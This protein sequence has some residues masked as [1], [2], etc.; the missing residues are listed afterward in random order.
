MNKKEL[1]KYIKERR[2]QLSITQNDIATSLN[3]TTQAVSRWENGLSCPDFILLGDLSDLLKVTIDDLLTLNIPSELY[4]N[5]L[6]FNYLTFGQTINKYLEYNNLT[7][8][9]FSNKSK[10]NQT[11]ISNIINGKAFPSINQFITIANI[12][13]IK[14]S[15][16]YF[17][18]FIIYTKYV[19]SNIKNNINHNKLIISISVLLIFILGIIRIN[20]SEK[21]E[22]NSEIKKDDNYAYIEFWDQNANLLDCQKKEYG[23]DVYNYIEYHPFL[24]WNREISPAKTSTI[25]KMMKNPAELALYIHYDNYASYYFLDSI[26]DF[27]IYSLYKG[28]YY[29]TSLKDYF[30]NPFDINNITPGEYELHAELSPRKTH[31]IFFPNFLNIEPISIKTCE[32]LYDLPIIYNENY[33]IIG[34][35]YNNNELITNKP[36][37]YDKSIELEPIYLDQKIKVNNKGII[38][39]LESNEDQIIIPDYY[40][41][42]QI[43]EIAPNSI[44]LNSNNKIIRFWNRSEIFFQDVFYNPSLTNNIKEIEIPYAGFKPESYLGNIPLLDKVYISNIKETNTKY[45]LSNLSTNPNFLIDNLTLKFFNNFNYKNLNV[46]NVKFETSFLDLDIEKEMFKNSTIKSCKFSSE[47]LANNITI[48]DK[49]FYECEYLESFEFPFNTNLSGDYHFYNCKSLKNVTFYGSINYLSNY[50]FSNTSLKKLIINKKVKSIRPNAFLN[51][52]LETIEIDMAENIPN[53]CFLPKSLKNFYIG[54]ILSNLQFKNE[55]N[56]LTIHYLDYR[57]LE[58]EQFSNFN[59]NI[60]V[61][62]IHR[63][64][65]E[66]K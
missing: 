57:T 10:I 15:D 64:K 5:D 18:K 30:N 6:K 59:Y 63:H 28:D 43:K 13:N 49:A 35:S 61:N 25:Y 45:H 7:Q 36:F 37:P 53:D 8:R 33:F 32:V 4:Y 62:C 22:N 60:C 52:Y 11:T 31:S 34:Y 26:E 21:S 47:I 55:D 65:G 14:Y 29:C 54:G 16:L 23:K 48:Y 58:K 41:N 1:G 44:H 66:Y 39:Y 9:E 3:I 17:S 42:I 50:M 20:F 38:T 27:N 2:E 40:N 24:G 56:N 19:Y 12:F 46:N 51:T